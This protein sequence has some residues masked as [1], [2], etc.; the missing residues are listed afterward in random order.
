[1]TPLD[2]LVPA[3]LGSTLLLFFNLLQTYYRSPLKDIPGP[4]LAKITNL[5]RLFDVW[6]GR[7]ELTQ[8]MLHRKY[9]SAVRLGPNVV[10]LSDPR[11]IKTI[12]STRGEYLKA[13][14][15]SPPESNEKHR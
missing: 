13:S 6:G 3:L 4:F 8:R 5:W 12:Y 9:G 7:P 10:S 2:L 1:M 11:L 14:R 15:G